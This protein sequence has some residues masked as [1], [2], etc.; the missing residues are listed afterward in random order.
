MRLIKQSMFNFDGE[1]ARIG[2]LLQDANGLYQIG[3]RKSGVVLNSYC[4]ASTPVSMQENGECLAGEMIV[5]CKKQ[6]VI[7]CVDGWSRIAEKEMPRDKKVSLSLI[8]RGVGSFEEG[9]FRHT[10][11]TLPLKEDKDSLS[12]TSWVIPG[13]LSKDILAED[14]KNVVL[15]V[16][17]PF[18]A[19]FCAREVLQGQVIV[20]EDIPS[21]IDAIKKYH[22]NALRLALFVEWLGGCLG[23]V[24]ERQREKH[25]LEC[26]RKSLVG[27]SLCSVED[28]S[29]IVKE[30]V[31]TLLEL[32]QKKCKRIGF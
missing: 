15:K 27:V 13:A 21:N 14:A 8:P 31:I 22:A 7:R 9:V 12:P 17:K 28:A 25:R 19:P 23:N 20:L 32:T 26:V 29:K 5:R 11:T 10:R 1:R 2:K 16:C 18:I 24:N 4:L 3:V 6:S 30:E